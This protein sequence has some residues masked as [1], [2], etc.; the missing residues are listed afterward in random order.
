MVWTG[1]DPRFGQSVHILKTQ[2][3]N[4]LENQYISDFLTKIPVPMAET[5]IT[6]HL[7]HDRRFGQSSWI[8]AFSGMDKG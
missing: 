8:P 7:G 4:Y 6:A 2:G 3:Y 1:G 5:R